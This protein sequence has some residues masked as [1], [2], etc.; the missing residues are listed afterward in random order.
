MKTLVMI[1]TY[2]EKENIVKLIK[3]ILGLKINGLEIL[4]VDDNSPDGTSHKVQKIRNKNKKVHL[5]LR[6]EDKGRG[7]AGREGFLWCIKHK[8]DYI[9]EMDADFSHDP[10]Y[11]PH[12]LAKLKECD[13]VLGSRFVKGG[14]QIKRPLRRCFITWAANLYIRLLF[15]LK[16]K[17]CNSG[18]RAFRRKV[19]ESIDLPHFTAKG[20]D[21]V[22]ETLYRAHLKGFRICEVPIVFRER[23][24][25]SSK[26]GMKQLW[27][28]YTAVLR[29][30]WMHL[31]GII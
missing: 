23:E 22:Q 29:L 7:K 28:G 11:I 15:R 21:I 12:L 18:Y 20:P 31:R 1:P 13:M 9:I 6:T 26:L 8:A 14:K 25:G 30:K 10:K 19:L 16:V 3:K 2:N 17:D 24:A 5:L 4:V 27:K